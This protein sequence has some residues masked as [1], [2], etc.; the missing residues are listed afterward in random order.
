MTLTS[1]LD[2]LAHDYVERL[3]RGERPGIEAYAGHHP[4]LAAEIN[5][6]FPVLRVI[7]QHANT[8]ADVA[9]A[10]DRRRSAQSIRLAM[11]INELP[12]E[13]R[14]VVKLHQLRGESVAAIAEALGRT[15]ADVAGLLRR[16]LRHIREHTQP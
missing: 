1:L 4:A 13:E 14:R 9:G 8:S 7:E 16:G 3:R 5:E 6:L 12:D 11:A 2:E 10:S 15:V